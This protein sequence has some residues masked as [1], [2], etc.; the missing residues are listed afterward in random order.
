[1]YLLSEFIVIDIYFKGIRKS[2]FINPVFTYFRY[3]ITIVNRLVANILL[4][5]NYF[6]LKGFNINLLEGFIVRIVE[7][8]NQG[9]YS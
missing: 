3:G 4:N 5:I 7:V 1:M 6:I 8:I 9:N 2:N